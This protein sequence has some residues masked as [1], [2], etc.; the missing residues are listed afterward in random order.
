MNY[1]PK[2]LFK[3]RIK[4]LLRNEQDIEKFWQFSQKH[5]PKTI[6][7]N[8]LKISTEELKNRL[9]NKGWEIK[10][11]FQDFPEI[12]IVESQ[13]S[14]GELGKSIEHLLGYFYVQE[15]S[16]M[17]P[18]LALQPQEN[19]ILLDLCASPGSKTTQASAL[20]KNKGTIIANDKDIARI[21][22]LSANL[23][24]VGASNVIITRHDGVQLCNKLEKLNMKF[25]KML[26][27][28][29]CSGEGNIR[30]NEATLRMWNIKV[31]NKL[32]RIQKK[33]AESALQILKPEGI[34]VYS[35]CT[36]SPEENEL[37]IQYLLD[38]YNLKI[39]EIKLPLKTREGITSWQ[40]K[41]LSPEL[42]K[43]VR[44]Y[45]QDNN[46]EGFFLC[47]MKKINERAVAVILFHDNENNITLQNRKN[48][49]KHGEKY[50]FFGGK[51]EE[52]EN[53]EQ[54]IKREIKEELGIEIKNFK[55]FRDY[56]ERIEELNTTLR[57]VVF[58]AKMP[59]IKKIKEGEGKIEIMKFKDSFSLKM[60]QGDVE[61]L[62]E[63][64]NKLK[65]GK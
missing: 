60:I 48:Y 2:P 25:D 36:H 31:I 14:P 27:D 57:R 39:Q 19:D 35:T 34:L 32:G 37:V 23:E 10:Q 53:P 47:K 50:G 28:A 33:L 12:M 38:N 6:R 9:Q 21:S 20:M 45:P 43:A 56:T 26:V 58:L 11:Q 13:L 17:M 52:G 7:C 1:Q 44:I 65:K 42:K 15:V 51:I 64:Y 49:S 24:R 54:A 30:S 59:D 18:I 40:G 16:S 61:L 41:E 55:L 3:E 4:L 29:P 5:L 22:I 63:I 8:T 46:T 62:K